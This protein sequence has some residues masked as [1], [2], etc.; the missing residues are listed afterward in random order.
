MTEKELVALGMKLEQNGFQPLN[1]RDALGVISLA[2]KIRK[3]RDEYR[4][5][6]QDIQKKIGKAAHGEQVRK[7]QEAVSSDSE[8]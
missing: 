8:D 4:A 3:E 5:I 2:L 1:N 6:L 7:M